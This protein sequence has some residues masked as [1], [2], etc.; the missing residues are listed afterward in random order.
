MDTAT[1]YYLYKKVI[2]ENRELKDQIRILETILRSHLPVLD[3]AFIDL[4][5]YKKR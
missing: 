4:S 1:F 2:M 5:K 3:T